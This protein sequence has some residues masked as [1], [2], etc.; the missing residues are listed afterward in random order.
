MSI[1]AA[2]Q[3][4]LW[5][6]PPEYRRANTRPVTSTPAPASTDEENEENPA[7]LGGFLAGA[8]PA[9]PSDTTPT[10]SDNSH[11][12][13]LASAKPAASEGETA[14]QTDARIKREKAEFQAR[15][16]REIAAQQAGEMEEARLF[17]HIQTVNAQALQ[18]QNDM[19]NQQDINTGELEATIDTDKVHD[20]VDSVGQDIKRLMARAQTAGNWEQSR[21]LL[22]QAA[23]LVGDHV[24]ELDSIRS[25]FASKLQDYT[26]NT[27]IQMQLQGEIAD[28]DDKQ[29]T[30][31][32]AFKAF[33]MAAFAARDTDSLRSVSRIATSEGDMDMAEASDEVRR[34]RRQRQ[35]QQTADVA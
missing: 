10:E 3:I 8:Q 32:E 34:Q 26:G 29:S 16:D 15:R 25:D 19:R 1:E 24:T 6:V 18:A 14:E 22:S 11:K 23:D 30:M 21:K 20:D 35:Q 9:P 4:G 7:P 28:I 12:G 33:S 2:Q 17:A 13:F 5:A 27:D 31:Q